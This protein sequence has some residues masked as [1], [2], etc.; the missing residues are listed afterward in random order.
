M[1]NAPAECVPLRTFAI[2]CAVDATHPP[3]KVLLTNGPDQRLIGPVEQVLLIDR[4]PII[5]FHHLLFLPEHIIH[6]INVTIS[7]YMLP[8]AS[9]LFI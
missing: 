6:E 3:V 1:L 2:D 4:F 9:L 7:S 5:L 8:C